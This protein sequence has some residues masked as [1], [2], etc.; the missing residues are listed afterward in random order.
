[1]IVGFIYNL[2]Y[3]LLC[4]ATVLFLCVWISFAMEII[5]F[6]I[7][8]IHRYIKIGEIIKDIRKL[9]EQ[10]I[11]FKKYRFNINDNEGYR[12]Y[13]DYVTKL[14]KILKKGEHNNLWDQIK[15]K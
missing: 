7:Y 9:K 6:K 10:T 5:V 8:D 14:D 1:M 12:I 2:L 15:K 3:F 11:E 13:N 4:L